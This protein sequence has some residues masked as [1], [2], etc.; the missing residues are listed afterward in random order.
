MRIV[1][2]L[3]VGAAAA[4]L[5]GCS[6]GGPAAVESKKAQTPAPVAYF[7]VDPATAGTIS[8]RISFKG[9][10]PAPKPIVMNEEAEC[11]K[12]HPGGMTTEDV[13][14][15]ADGTLANVFV[16]LK[17][18][19]EGKSF[20]P[21][22][23]PIAIDQRGCRFEPHVMA[24]RV[25]QP[26]HV[27]NSD[28][29]THNIHPQPKDNRE[30]NQGQPPGSATLEREFARP[31]IMIPVKCNVHSWMRSYI[32]VLDH[33]YFAVARDGAFEIKNVPPGDYTVVAWHEKLGVQEMKV[34]VAPSGKA[35]AEF[36]YKGA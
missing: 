11:V 31:E 12:M 6:G 18:G 21:V 22:T 26:F 35:V 17:T 10:R 23:V 19:L 20:E 9:A 32:A 13:V 5:I 4:M 1:N 34:T 36:T 33:P 16:Y 3:N 14:V 27:T 8:G 25:G 24:V 15:N 29:V 28:P 7:K 30:W 2:L